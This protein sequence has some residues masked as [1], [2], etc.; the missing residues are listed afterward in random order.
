MWGCQPP[1]YKGALAVLCRGLH[2]VRSRHLLPSFS[3]PFRVT[4]MTEQ[5]HACICFFTFHALVKLL[6]LIS[7]HSYIQLIKSGS[8]QGPCDLLAARWAPYNPH[9]LVPPKPLTQ[10][11]HPTH[12]EAYPLFYEASV[13]PSFLEALS[14]PLFSGLCLSW[15]HVS[16]LSAE[17]LKDMSS[18]VLSTPLH[19]CPPPVHGQPLMALPQTPELGVMPP[20]SASP[21]D[22]QSCSVVSVCF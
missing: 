18:S 21:P 9:L 10:C 12:W 19:T 17:Y 5:L 6:G 13:C 16:T 3:R 1:C 20:K 14:P 2:L 4:F 11:P 15:A 22:S 7:P 8:G